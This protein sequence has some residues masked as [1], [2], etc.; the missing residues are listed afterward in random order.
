MRKTYQR[1]GL[2]IALSVGGMFLWRY[3]KLQNEALVPEPP[4]YT[5]T[6]EVD[7][8]NQMADQTEEVEPLPLE[9]V[10]EPAMD[11][12]AIAET[13]PSLELL[14][15]FLP[16]WL[17]KSGSLYQDRRE[18]NGRLVLRSRGRYS[19]GD[20]GRLEIEITDVGEQADEAVIKSLG[21]DL[22]LEDQETETG[23]SSVQ[24][25][26]GYLVN[27]EYDQEDQCGSLQ[28]LVEGR[29]LIEIQLEQFPREAFQDVLDQD[30]PFDAIF[31]QL[32]E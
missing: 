15:S 20:G 8:T 18:I 10:N 21:F 7:Q 2:I 25:V 14:S 31:D 11:Q 30:I 4:V 26:E 3:I 12:G 23:F 28:I 6:A 16:D 13:N 32:E 1:I 9:L 27:H 22:N 17:R 29:F 24:D 19:W 5:K